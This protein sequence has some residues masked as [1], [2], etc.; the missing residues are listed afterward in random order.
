MRNYIKKLIYN[1]WPEGAKLTAFLFVL[2]LLS[3]CE[4]DDLVAIRSIDTIEPVI[5][6]TTVVT[7]GIMTANKE[8]EL[9]E[10]GI[11]YNTSANPVTEDNISPGTDLEVFEDPSRYT[12]EFKSQI[13]LLSP[14]T[15]YYIRAFVT[16]RTGT[17]YGN[18]ISFTVN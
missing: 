14:G 17:A 1:Y 8:I 4:K 11:A 16:T 3:G 13:S 12:A 2:I 6:G 15:T 18:Q 10:Y 9:V 7:G 5:T